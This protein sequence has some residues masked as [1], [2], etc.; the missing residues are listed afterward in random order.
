VHLAG[1]DFEIHPIDPQPRKI[2]QAAAILR[3]GG[4]IAYPTDSSYALGCKLGD[5]AAAKR[6]RRIRGVGDDHHL[7]LV[8]RD[9]SGI[10]HFA[11]LDNWQFRSGG[12]TPGPFT[13][14]PPATRVVP[15]T[16]ALERSTIGVCARASV[17]GTG[18]ARRA[19]PILD[20][21]PPDAREP[22]NDAQEFMT[23]LRPRSIQIDAD[24]LAEPATV[25]DSR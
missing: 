13:F 21:D 2:R 1:A 6:I 17:V 5:A 15:E 19:D 22:L 14:V 25:V 23:P 20:A 4:V 10:G 18:R 3:E 11:R 12:S 16:S 8:L 9:L 7:T 24:C